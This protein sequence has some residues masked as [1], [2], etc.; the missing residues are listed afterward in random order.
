VLF[1]GIKNQTGGQGQPQATSLFYSLKAE[2][3]GDLVIT[4]VQEETGGTEAVYRFADA[5]VVI[6]VNGVE[7]RAQEE[8]VRSDLSQGFL[9]D[10][11]PEGQV[12]S[13]RM[14]PSVKEFSR[15]F[16][17]ALIAATQFVLPS[18]RSGSANTW[19]YREEDRSG[20]YLARYELA[21]N[22]PQQIPQQS[23][24]ANCAAVRKRKLR[25]FLEATDADAG[26]LPGQVPAQKVIT[27]SGSLEGQFDVTQGRL[28]SLRGEDVQDTQIEGKKVAHSETTLRMTDAGLRKLSSEETAGV[29]QLAAS[30]EASG[31]RLPL[32]AKP[33]AEEM[34]T[35]IQQTELGTA[36]LEGL[37]SDLAAL[38]V[39]HET[40]G[41]TDLYLKFKALVYLHPDSCG[42]LGEILGTAKTNGPTFRILA[43]ALGAIGNPQAQRA[44]IAAIRARPQDWPA[45]SNLIPTLSSA[46]VPI[47]DAEKELQEL[48]AT[49]TDPNISGTAVLSLGTVAHSLA[50][51]EPARAAEIVDE[52]MQ[53]VTVSQTEGQTHDLIEALGNSA[54]LRALP[55]LSKFASGPS[56]RLRAA[57]LDALRLMDSKQADALLILGLTTDSDSGVRLE[58]AYSLGFREM[59][60]DSYNS[61]KKV[62]LAESDEKVRAAILVNLWKARGNFS[63]ARRIVKEAAEND[64]SEY[65]QK[66]A[67]GLL[68]EN[69]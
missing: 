60:P 48:A 23:S 44:L 64:P 41:E 3:R 14:M 46:P 53:Q 62:L 7:Q 45:L 27:P 2:F 56:P 11:T 9:V 5:A 18:H 38:E 47:P 20:P 68:S 67:K 10:R 43:G 12:L 69:P 37:L 58:A 51:K 26:S 21:G 28:L 40:A 6:V 50:S 35:N 16:A 34:Q 4:E 52:L 22:C 66:I 8:I 13:L 54:S 39:S 55:L 25:Y 59:T 42:R 31:V 36:T 49:S 30:L 32:Y 19:E 15:Q 57:A 63:D 17:L 61:Q 29:R 33:S 1:E 24:R 65:V